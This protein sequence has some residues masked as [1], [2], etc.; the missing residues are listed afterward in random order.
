MGNVGPLKSFQAQEDARIVGGV[1]D[2]RSID[3][4]E[5]MIFIFSICVDYIFKWHGYL[6]YVLQMARAFFEQY[7]WS[8]GRLLTSTN[9]VSPSG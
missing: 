9:R 7:G 5:N 4:M 2:S 8:N 3:T 6:Y 1:I